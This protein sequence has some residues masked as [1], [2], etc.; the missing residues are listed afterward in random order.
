MK[1]L[2]NIFSQ[3]KLNFIDELI[4]A[5]DKIE[6]L[7]QNNRLFSKLSKEDMKQIFLNDNIDYDTKYNILKN[8]PNFVSKIDNQDFY[9]IIAL[10]KSKM[11]VHRYSDKLNQLNYNDY[12][13]CLQ[14][15]NLYECLLA[16]SKTTKFLQLIKEEEKTGKN[17][18]KIY[19]LAM[20]MYSA[21]VYHNNLDE[22]KNISNELLKF[23]IN[24]NQLNIDL[25]SKIFFDYFNENIKEFELEDETF[26]C[27]FEL[28]NYNIK[29]NLEINTEMFE[30][31]VK[32]R[33]KEL[34]LEDFVYKV[35]IGEETKL[36][37]GYN[38]LLKELVIDIG[39]IRKD[40]NESFGEVNVPKK[41][42]NNF[43]NLTA[44][45]TISHELYHAKTWKNF[46]S[47]NKCS[48]LAD[49]YYLKSMQ[50]FN[51]IEYNKY[52]DNHEKFIEEMRA[53]LFS[54]LDL[55]IQLNKNFK[56]VFSEFK[57]KNYMGSCA[58]EIIKMY[59]INEEEYKLIKS[60]IEKFQAFYNENPIN[61]LE[62]SK[63]NKKLLAMLPSP[64]PILERNEKIIYLQSSSI[65][66][67]L[68]SGFPIPTEILFKI[69][70]VANGEIK[71]TNI[72]ETIL[73]FI[74]EY[75]NTKEESEKIRKM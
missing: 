44:L 64:E 37:G 42:Y 33:I 13:K 69:N 53:D 3:N 21:T 68:L 25:I 17:I 54:I 10:L 48:L 74:S 49:V 31:Y 63:K 46:C 14:S 75:E 11:D 12:L 24:N 38:P 30:F 47:K 28:M 43:I 29:N 52:L 35:I 22:F 36:L 72:Y 40:F 51:K 58:S 41:E 59:T 18:L 27:A 9:I 56:N 61:R 45:K 4:D 32:Y 65:L 60:P 71:T 67:K 66:G 8:Y 6:F 55:C 57:L 15:N 73:E 20:N 34:N 39:I 2:D 70:K 16:L 62:V 26:K 19:S 50:L 1:L 5:K 7:N 23:L